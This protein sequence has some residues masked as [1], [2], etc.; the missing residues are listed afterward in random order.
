MHCESTGVERVK[1]NQHVTTLNHRWRCGP[2]AYL[3]TSTVVRHP[4]GQRNQHCNAGERHI[5]S[6][7]DLNIF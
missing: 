1:K 5:R 7:C 4:R 2:Q 3:D 6:E